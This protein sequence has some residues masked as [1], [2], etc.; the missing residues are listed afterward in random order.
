MDK[1]SYASIGILSIG[2]IVTVL[3]W[4]TVFV[5]I[6][7]NYLNSFQDDSQSMIN[8]IES[9]LELYS[10]SLLG[11]VGLFAAS[12]EV[13]N[14]EWNIFI[15]STKLIDRY[16]GIQ[17]V[18]FNKYLTSESEKTDLLN[19][20]RGYG[21]TDF[22]IKPPGE[23]SEYFPVVYLFP[24]NE[25][26]KR[27]IG[28]DIYS[29]PNRAD[30]V[31][32]LKLTKEMAITAKIILVQES[33]ED[34]Q[35][36]FLM[37]LPVF[38]NNNEKLI[39]LIS[40]V[41]RMNDL[42]EAIIEKEFF[43]KNN[44][45][46]YD[47]KEL[48]DSL[49]FDSNELSG[50]TIFD[51]NYVFRDSINFGGK[52]WK[53]IIQS[54]HYPLNDSD[55]NILILIPVVGFG[56]S[57]MGYFAF[58]NFNK[59][60]IAKQIQK[61]RNEFE[62]MMSHE[63]KTPLVPIIGYCDML[64]TPNLLGKLNDDQLNAVNRILNNTDHI[65]KL[66]QNIL[67]IQKIDLEQLKLQYSIVNL[68]EFISEIIVSHKAIMTEK[69]INFSMSNIPSINVKMDREK[70]KEVMT[71]IIQNAVDFVPVEKGIIRIEGK[72]LGEKFRITISNNGQ[73]IPHEEL[74]LIFK[75]FHQVESGEKRM[76]GGSG[77]GLA[78]CKGIIESH[79][80]K[81]W[82]ES[83][84]KKTSIIFEIPSNINNNQQEA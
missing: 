50:F 38:D 20:M 67:D 66:I 72:E 1:T 33:E 69:N 5:L 24:E 52:D 25:A 43:E 73:Q 61:R 8:K 82:A 39:G 71:N 6:E 53:F 32:N 64:L 36:G 9:R 19:T 76:H 59:S 45:K 47:S 75:K 80:G 11:T 29:E 63:L 26:N 81:M 2:I 10:V 16:P 84:S 7:E 65:K 44:I 62:S 37:L 17:G 35:N 31:N 28:Y 21:I 79:G 60:V 18:G 54:T 49:F 12:E 23:R 15:N 4:W 34:T 30:A 68:R 14:E 70:I 57:I 83:N 42:M 74:K 3:T 51:E 27:A 40:A 48:P 78:I 58:I 46:I 55:R 77:L 56:I 41:F 13:T 22:E